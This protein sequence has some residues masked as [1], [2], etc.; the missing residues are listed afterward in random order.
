MTKP[1]LAIFTT[2]GF[3]TMVTVAGFT[4]TVNVMDADENSAAADCVAVIVATPTALGT[5]TF[6][7]AETIFGLD[8]VKVQSPGE[9]EVGFE[10]VID[11]SLKLDVRFAI[12]PIVG[13]PRTV[14]VN[15]IGVDAA[16]SPLAD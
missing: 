3:Q 10:S 4:V 15:A 7:V 2:M 13:F 6:P 9:F 14:T 5:R 11:F 1:A 8:D 12:E 16:K